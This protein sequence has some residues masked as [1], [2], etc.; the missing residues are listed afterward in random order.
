MDLR[1]F[2]PVSYWGKAEPIAITNIS[3]FKN[4]CHGKISNIFFNNIVA[5]T[6]NGL[7][8]YT[9]NYGDINNIKLNNIYLNIHKKTKWE[10]GFHD[11]RPA[12]GFGII[13]TMLNVIYSNNVENLEY[14]N[15]K[16]DIDDAVLNIKGED[17][18]FE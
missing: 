12:E 10:L 16:Y 6:E 15:F 9:D 2:E 11:L 14:N 5:D 3:R 7:F 4:L 8:L 13:K 1:C 17:F 18:K